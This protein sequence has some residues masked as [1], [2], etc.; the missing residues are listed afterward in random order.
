MTQPRRS[1][2]KKLAASAAILAGVSAFVSFG[3]FS[4]FT[5]SV[6]N[7][8]NLGSAKIELTNTP[9]STLI[10][11]LN[12]IPGDIITRCVAV[13]NTGDIASNV[14]ITKA[15]TGST[16]LLGGLLASVE[17]GT[18]ASGQTPDSSCTGFTS[19]AGGAVYRMGSSAIS[20]AGNYSGGVAP[21]SLSTEN[22]TG[23]AAG[24]TKY[25]RIKI[26]LPLDAANTLQS[27]TS[28]LGLT[29]TASS[30]AGDQNR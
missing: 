27:L 15:T 6:S 17:E 12:L 9:T 5:S 19:D 30:P 24:T 21:S 22:Y 8:S 20:T 4:A 3:A 25:F 18:V 28:T 23:W 10:N 14:S 13:Q 26:A 7:D 2:A 11:I 16:T 1:T 29:F